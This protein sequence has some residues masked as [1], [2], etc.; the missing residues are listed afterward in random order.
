MGPCLRCLY[1]S[2]T[3]VLFVVVAHEGPYFSWRVGYRPVT[4][5]APV[6][7]QVGLLAAS[8][9]GLFATQPWH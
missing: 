3:V 8:P 5:V 6:G 4:K 9:T 1:I 2:S 7:H